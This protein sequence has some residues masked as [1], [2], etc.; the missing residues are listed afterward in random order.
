MTYNVVRYLYPKLKFRHSLGNKNLSTDQ[1]CH[2]VSHT[3]HVGGNA[4]FNA[5]HYL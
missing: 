1:I 5:F 2:A 4:S 3:Q